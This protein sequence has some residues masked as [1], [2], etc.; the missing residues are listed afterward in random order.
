M[1]RAI[2]IKWKPV[3]KLLIA[4][5]VIYLFKKCLDILF[6]PKIPCLRFDHRSREFFLASLQN[7]PYLEKNS[8][9]IADLIEHNEKN[10]KRWLPSAKSHPYRFMIKSAQLPFHRISLERWVSALEN[11]CLMGL[12]TVEIDVVWT[13][14]EPIRGAFD[15][16]Q[17]SN[18][19]EEFI[20]LVK[21]H[22]L[23]LIVRINPYMQCSDYDFGGLPSWLLGEKKSA[24]KE[25]LL[26]LKN[27][28]F[29]YP[30]ESYLKKLL[31]I[32]EKYQALNDG[33]IIGIS[34]QNYAINSLELK[35]DIRSFPLHEF[36]NNDYVKFLQDYLEEFGIYEALV[37][38][39]PSCDYQRESNIEC[40]PNMS[41]YLSARFAEYNVKPEDLRFDAKNSDFYK[42]CLGK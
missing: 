4:L 23:F 29:I 14:H 37:T 11:V 26:N 34:L 1:S 3:S 25:E 18:D 33:P 5:L 16:S 27:T 40:D 2:Q 19:L 20:K 35:A 28:N 30:F 9:L 13:V 10:K 8:D 32:L 42:N 17:G 21:Y 39:I 41:V 6:A 36:Y 31:P 7:R 15:F 24:N 38:S 22:N 12:N